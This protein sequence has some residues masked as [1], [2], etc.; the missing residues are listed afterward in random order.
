MFIV[1][2]AVLGRG[3]FYEGSPEH[4]GNIGYAF[5]TLFQLLTLDDWFELLDHVTDQDDQDD[6][7]V[8]QYWTM[9]I[10]LFCYIV[11][12][13]FVFLKCVNACY[14]FIPKS[15]YAFNSE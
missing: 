1:V 8:V 6:N 7:K 3:L 14:F 13:Y 11:I 4:F 5:V 15:F 10:Y 9:F 2:F 12:E